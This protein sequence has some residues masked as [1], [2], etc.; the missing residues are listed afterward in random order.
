MK[1]NTAYFGMLLSLALIC[2][3]VESLITV[4]FGVPG[5]KLGLANIVAV[6]MLYHDGVKAVAVISVLRILL[7]GFL[8]GNPFSII[9][10]LG[11][12]LLSLAVMCLLKRRFSLNVAS[13]SVAGGI[14][15]NI[16]QLC[17]AS[18]VVENYH[19]FYYAPMLL[20]AGTATGFLIGVLSREI[21]FRLS[22]R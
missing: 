10:S 17:V 5:V 13:V 1:R 22:G 6:V 8:F 2:G 18:A 19:I 15:H 21:L 7:G 3:Y 9:Y 16:G 11:G 20:L 14:S 12:G 4:S